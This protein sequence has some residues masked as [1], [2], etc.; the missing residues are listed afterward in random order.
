VTQREET[1]KHLDDSWTFEA[2]KN[3]LSYDVEI[4]PI[5]IAG[6]FS[7]EIKGAVEELDRDAYRIKEP[8]VIAPAR[9]TVDINRLDMSGYPEFSGELTLTKSFRLD[10][11]D[12]HVTLVGRGI[13]CIHLTVNGKYV[14]KKLFGPYDVDISDHLVKGENTLELK[15]VN[16]LRNMQGPFHMKEGEC[17]GVG[18]RAFFRESNV[19]SHPAGAGE[20]CHDVLPWWH[21]DICLVHYGVK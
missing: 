20:S 5:Y 13:N 9:K 16:N 7:A 18:P 19:F 17:F 6:D 2:M 12:H 1:Y 15:I 11:T 4:E 3:C 21:D 14:T 8:P 10:G